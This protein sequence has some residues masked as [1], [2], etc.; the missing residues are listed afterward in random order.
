M[1]IFFVD[2]HA[3]LLSGEDEVEV[4]A[5]PEPGVEGEPGDDEVELGFGEEEEGECRPVHEPGG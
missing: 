5:Q 3:P 4:D 2:V 1:N